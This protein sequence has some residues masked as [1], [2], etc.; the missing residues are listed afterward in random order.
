MNDFSTLTG[1]LREIWA[2]RRAADL[3]SFFTAFDSPNSDASEIAE[4]AHELGITSEDWD[5][6]KRSK[7]AQDAARYEASPF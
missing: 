5:A 2:E 6:H 4:R 1:M 3:R 7:Q